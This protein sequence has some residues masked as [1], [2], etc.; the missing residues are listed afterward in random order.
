MGQR[1]FLHLLHYTPGASSA[2]HA[3]GPPASLGLKRRVV[4]R[5]MNSASRPLS[6]KTQSKELFLP[7]WVGTYLLSY[8][9]QSPL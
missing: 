4:K 9:R 1:V 7:S 3:P 8:V 5:G 6:I 2:R